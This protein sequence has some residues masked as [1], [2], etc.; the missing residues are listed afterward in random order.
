[1]MDDVRPR[2]SDG[3]F[4]RRAPVI[5]DDMAIGETD[6]RVFNCPSCSRPLVKGTLR[7]PNCG[8]R[9][10]LGLTLRRVSAILISGAVVGILIGSAAMA[11]A[12]GAAVPPGV[13]GVT[14]AAATATATAEATP[15]AEPTATP[16]A[17]VSTPFVGGPPAA[18]VAALS[19]IAVVNS[20]LAVD[21]D[22][23]NEA[24]ANR[25]STTTEYARALRSLAADAALGSDLAGRLGP[26]SSAGT[27]RTQLDAFYREMSD[28]ARL[29]LR[30]SLTDVKGYRAA[31]KAMR[32]AVAGLTDVDAA[33]RVL[34]STVPVELPPLRIP[35]PIDP[36]G[37]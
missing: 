31:A 22:A 28:T 14:P 5:G 33:T 12:I 8:K 27:V 34:A 32:S 13:A 7:C 6:T 20:R 21:V 16:V 15:V 3:R 10:F 37:S 2:S 35:I 23:L 29:G 19:G 25:A 30:T 4:R 36:A 1:M 11:I 17:V 26:W 18:A 24:L 9:L